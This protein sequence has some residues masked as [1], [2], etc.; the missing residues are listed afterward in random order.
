MPQQTIRVVALGRDNGVQVAV[1]KTWAVDL[2]DGETPQQAAQ[3]VQGLVQ[4]GVKDFLRDAI[5]VTQSDTVV[6]VGLAGG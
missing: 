6:S 2:Q 3:R 1:V 4:A 5:R